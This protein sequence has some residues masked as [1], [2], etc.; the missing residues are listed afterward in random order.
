MKRR[1]DPRDPGPVH[2]PHVLRDAA[3]RPRQALGPDKSLGNSTGQFILGKTLSKS[4]ARQRPRLRGEG[5]GVGWE[6]WA[7]TSWRRKF[8]NEPLELGARIMGGRGEGVGGGV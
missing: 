1:L 2:R 7:S 3:P 4:P 6:E 8:R 5:P